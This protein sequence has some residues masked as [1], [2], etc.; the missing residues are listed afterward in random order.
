MQGRSG[1]W[2]LTYVMSIEISLTV[3][4]LCKERS[5]ED[6]GK[7]R[8]REKEEDTLV[9]AVCIWVVGEERDIWKPSLLNSIQIKL[10]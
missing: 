9:P 1:F 8:G 4:V 3:T 6:V 5:G 10:V 7:R 2:F